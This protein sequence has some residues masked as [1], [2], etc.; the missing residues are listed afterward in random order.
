VRRSLA[1]YKVKEHAGIT[2]NKH[3]R[4]AERNIVSPSY[5]VIG[6]SATVSRANLGGG[7]Y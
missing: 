2:G 4:L 1:N 6:S 5:E 3:F 7:N